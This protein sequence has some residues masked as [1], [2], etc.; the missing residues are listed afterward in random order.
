MTDVSKKSGYTLRR[1]GLAES[2]A[3]LEAYLEG[4][5]E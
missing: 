5:E 3:L 4:T 2:A 1:S